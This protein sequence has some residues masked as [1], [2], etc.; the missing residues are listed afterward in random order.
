[1]EIIFIILERFSIGE[2]IVELFIIIFFCFLLP[3]CV[4]V[5]PIRDC[6]KNNKSLFK[7][8][9]EEVFLFFIFILYRLR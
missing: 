3:M 1:M 7:E 9:K 2:N 8:Y 4:L 6:A 5:N